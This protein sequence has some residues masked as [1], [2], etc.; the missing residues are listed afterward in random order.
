M[1]HRTEEPKTLLVWHAP[2]LVELHLEETEKMISS[3]AER[4]TSGPMGTV[5]TY[6]PS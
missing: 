6:G 4:I 1:E 2:E 3:V 5:V